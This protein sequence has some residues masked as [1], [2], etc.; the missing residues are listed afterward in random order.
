M[1]KHHY[2]NPV[3]LLPSLR[4]V[5][6]LNTVEN[7]DYNVDIYDEDVMIYEEQ[8]ENSESHSDSSKKSNLNDESLYE[9]DEVKIGNEN[10]CKDKVN[11]IFELNG[12]AEQFLENVLKETESRAAKSECNS[13]KFE[14]NGV[15]DDEMNHLM[16][17]KCSRWSRYL[18]DATINNCCDDNTRD[19]LKYPFKEKHVVTDRSVK[20][21]DEEHF[22]PNGVHN[23]SYSLDVKSEVNSCFSNSIEI[24]MESKYG[25]GIG[26][27]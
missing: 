19:S 26:F 10:R 16:N 1:I 20:S 8:S 25:M 22:L 7:R 17:S 2:K 4:D 23:G 9:K 12:E 21:E 13:V 11:G 27:R 5:L 6:R 15:N 18:G 14:M 3:Q 24:D